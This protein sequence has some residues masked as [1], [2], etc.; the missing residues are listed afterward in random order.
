MTN[1]TSIL[2]PA[3]ATQALLLMYAP[4]SPANFTLR[5]AFGERKVFI[6]VSHPTEGEDGVIIV[7]PIDGE[8]AEVVGFLTRTPEKTF[9]CYD[10]GAKMLRESKSIIELAY[11]IVASHFQNPVTFG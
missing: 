4:M 8:I 6:T 1:T 2:S 11:D 3:P 10:H 9:R 5:A 7:Q